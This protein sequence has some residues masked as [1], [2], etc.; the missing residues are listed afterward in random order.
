MKNKISYYPLIIVMG[1]VLV[2]TSGCKKKICGCTDP[3]A[4]NFKSDANE[5]DGTCEYLSIGQS[6]QGGM[7]FYIDNTKEHGLICATS[8]QSSDLQWWNGT[9]VTTNATG[10]AV[11]TGQAN[12][13]AIV[14]AQGTG[15]Y[16]AQCC[17]DLSLNGY[18]D[19]FLPS[20]DELDLMYTNLQVEGHLSFSSAIYWSSTEFQYNTARCLDFT[21]GTALCWGSRDLKHYVRAVRAF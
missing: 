21:N 12:T 2:F 14:A 8:D 4:T 17:N 18:D 15:N 7:I 3:A 10:S 16:A 1:L 9:N 13:N 20:L 11:G 5:D 19:W 6:Y